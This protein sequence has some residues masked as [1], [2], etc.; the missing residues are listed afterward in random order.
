MISIE[1]PTIG[2]KT[3]LNVLESVREQTFQDYE[4]VV[5]DSSAE[6]VGGDIAREFGAHVIRKKTRLLG[7][8]ILLHKE[9]KGDRAL[10]L[11]STRTLHQNCLMMLSSFKEDMVVIAEKSIG[12][13][14]YAKAASLDMKLNLSEGNI[15]VSLE[16]LSGVVLPRFFDS[17]LLS[18]VIS[19]IEHRIGSDVE[20]IIHGDHRM[21]FIEAMTEGATVGVLRPELI[22]RLEDKDL[23][24]VIK[25]YFKY[26]LTARLASRYYPE[27]LRAR[28]RDVRGL[29][30]IQV[31]LLIYLY[32]L[33]AIPYSVGLLL[34]TII[35]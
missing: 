15:R 29:T 14:I 28:F 16:N 22:M 10:L 13:S 32:S 35:P 24:F 8:R 34:S 4:V 23:P 5:C 26:G 6:G 1:I 17:S 31:A 11:D 25:K 19:R 21:I 27:K 3:L 30:N 18:S 33:R 9:A 12:N 20:N 7:A 2:E